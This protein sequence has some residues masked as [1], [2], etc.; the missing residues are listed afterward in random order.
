MNSE[1]Q[2]TDLYQQ[3]RELIMKHSAEPLNAVRDRAFDD[4][5]RQ[6][7]PTRKT[8]KYKYTDVQKAFA[9]D[10][11]LNLSRISIP[12]NPQD[13][14]KC[15]VPNLSTQI[16]FVENDEKIG[17]GTNPYI[18][19]FKEM[20]ERNPE[21]LHKYYSR[22][23]DTSK[24][25]VTALNTALAQDGLVIHI[26]KNTRAEKPIQIVN[27]LRSGV[28]MMVNRRL[29]IVLEEGAE[30]T[31]LFCDHAM[32]NV[33]FLTTQVTEVYV[34]DNAR[35]DMYE[36]EETHTHCTRFSN[37]YAQTGRDSRMGHNSITLYNGTTRNT[38]QVSLCGENSEL[39]LNGCVV[40]DKTQHVDNN[41]LIDHKVPN[42]T[43]SQLYKYV[44]DENATGAFAGRILVEKDAQ[45]TL[46]T[47][48]NANLCASPTARMYTQPMLEIYAD[49]VKCAHGSTVGVLDNM[50]L[51]Y[52]QQRGIPAEEARMLLMFAFVGQVIDQVTLEPLRDRLHHLVEKRFRGELNKCTGCA[53]CK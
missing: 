30:A 22:L 28:D 43:S 20:A 19:S 48:N 9:H 32:D 46:S 42:C 15:D 47:E 35:L 29:L 17:E 45:K 38:T 3:C 50:A 6:G 37:L 13:A 10:Y 27:L 24:D 7:F 25:A 2:Y 14:F 5:V 39:V 33:R 52:M 1:K 44:I 40:A 36:L 18:Y 4:F 12:V 34:A 53:L 49:D 23:A 21:F 8:E 11:G 51:F 16:C 41:T 26:P 31:L